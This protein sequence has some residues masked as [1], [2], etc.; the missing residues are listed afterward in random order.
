MDF[1]PNSVEVNEITDIFSYLKSIDWQHEYWLYG[2]LVFHIIC[3][4]LAFLISLNFQIVLFMALLLMVYFSEYLNELA[5]TN[6]YKFS[7]QNYFDSNGMFI[8]IIFCCP[9]LLNCLFILARWLM[10]SFDLI[11]KVKT[12]QLKQEIKRKKDQTRKKAE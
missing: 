4:T 8:S 3:A 12:A 1:D 11:T 2:I 9:I 7:Q 6:A 5:A 10:M